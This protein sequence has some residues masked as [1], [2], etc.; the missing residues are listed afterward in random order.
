MYSTNNF[1]LLPRRQKK[2]SAAGNHAITLYDR[3]PKSIHLITEIDFH[4]LL[5]GCIAFKR[6]YQKQ[7]YTSFYD[8]LM[9]I[10]LRYAASND[11]ALEILNDSFLKIFK[12]IGKF[13]ALHESAVG[14]FKA[15]SK[16]IVIYTGIDH[17]RKYDKHNHHKDV[18]EVYHNIQDEDES[19]LD[20][21]SYKEIIHCV[22]QLSFAYRTVFSLFILDGFTHEEIGK[23]L[24]IAVGTSKSNLSKARQQLQQMLAKKHNYQRV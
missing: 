7:L 11:D 23:Q 1:T 8:Y 14:D 10:S 18:D 15:W 2:L 9:C 4:T 6:E 19:Q 21:L 5:Q 13:K 12:E 24:G 16:Q 22:Q 3:T 17:Y 20:K